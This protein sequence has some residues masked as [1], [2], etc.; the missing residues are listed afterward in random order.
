MCFSFLLCFLSLIYGGVQIIIAPPTIFPARLNSPAWNVGGP[1]GLVPGGA[2]DLSAGS[3]RLVRRTLPRQPLWAGLTG[4][5]KVGVWLLTCRAII[6]TLAHF[7]EH[8]RISA[9][10]HILVSS[11][12]H[13]YC[14]DYEHTMPFVDAMRLALC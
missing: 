9:H 13:Q 4:H 1:G 12:A 5:E 10:Q 11:L 14:V 8:S 3:R 7:N 2:D 6:G